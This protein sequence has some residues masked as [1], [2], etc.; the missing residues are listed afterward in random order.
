MEQGTKRDEKDALSAEMKTDYGNTQMRHKEELGDNCT[1]TYKILKQSGENYIG[2][3]K[4][5]QEKR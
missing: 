2:N 1:F 5:R 4:K 3:K